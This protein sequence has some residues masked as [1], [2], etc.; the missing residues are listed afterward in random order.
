MASTKRNRAIRK[1]RAVIKNRA[2]APGEVLAAAEALW[3]DE[4]GRH[5]NRK[6]LLG[7]L[8]RI[9]KNE[10][11][12]DASIDQVRLDGEIRI[13]AAQLREQI[14]A[15]QPPAPV[16]KEASNATP[17]QDIEEDVHDPAPA[18]PTTVAPAA[19]LA[20][21]P[22]GPPIVA[23]QTGF[24]DEVKELAEKRGEEI[25]DW[26]FLECLDARRPYSVKKV[27][28]CTLEDL[29]GLLP[30]YMEFD[31][32]ILEAGQNSDGS[33]DSTNPYV[34]R[35][36][37]RSNMMASIP[38]EGTDPMWIRQL[39]MR[40]QTDL[41]FLAK[42][43]F[44]KIVTNKTH[45]PVTDC[46]FP[47]KDPTVG[48]EEQAE[49]PRDYLLLMPR[50]SFKSTVDIVDC[51]QDICCWPDIR[52]IL[53]T[54]TRDLAVSFV[55]EAKNYFLVREGSIPTAFQKLFSHLTISPSDAGPI[56]E[57]RS[58]ARDLSKKE[59][60]LWA[61]SILT[62][63]PGWHT[64]KIRM[65]DAV[66]DKNA[67]T[68]ELRASVIEKASLAEELLDPGRGRA[69]YMLGTPWAPD[70]LYADS[71]KTKE[72]LK[73]LRAPAY[74]VKDGS[75]SKLFSELLE[76]DV[77][78]LFPERLGWA[79]LKRKAR[80]WGLFKSNYLLNPEG[81]TQIKFNLSTL[82]RQT[83]PDTQ[84]PTEYVS[85]MLAFDF[86]Y[87]T[88]EGSDS[89]VGVCLGWD[90]EGRGFLIDMVIGMYS[91]TELA[92]VVA[93]MYAKHKPETCRI[94]SSNGARFLENTIRFM[95]NRLNIQMNLDFFKVATTKGSKAYRVGALEP[96]LENGRL[97]ISASLPGLEELYK[98]FTEFGSCRH[99]DIP[100]AISFL[101][102]KWSPLAPPP[103]GDAKQMTEDLE[104][105]LREKGLH[106]LLYGMDEKPFAEDPIPQQ[107]DDPE[108]IDYFSPQGLK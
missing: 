71:M 33:G 74:T 60:S 46:F 24:Y 45:R 89:T 48:L 64:D 28:S 29:A 4:Y 23:S 72:G 80:K 26:H 15:W 39:R 82:E 103:P 34:Q 59:P 52:Q 19:E 95:G 97:F 91:D 105:R 92:S 61:A 104:A 12:P 6:H 35:A 63:L 9:V 106:D 100:D 75:Q 49:G 8:G 62:N 85:K 44:Q 66:S 67:N 25:N 69:V 5:N 90:S 73:V 77:I 21:F 53:L 108:I 68:P 27:P 42:E 93:E 22:D 30:L 99:D 32:S 102:N 79:Y 10:S 88:N 50:G 86:A 41:F 18:A 14:R 107:G 11:T 98:Q 78:L 84:L 1:R 43:F 101:A 51:V 87:S 7:P 3:S 96:L 20:T 17:A 40:A 54:G 76:E 83:I 47:F 13:R 70:D 94:E 31:A 58:P 2:S 57:L 16:V 81:T 37:G 56:D 55:T 36:R 65:D 38:E